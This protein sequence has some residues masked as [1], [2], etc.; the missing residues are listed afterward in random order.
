MNPPEPSTGAE[1]AR[2]VEHTSHARVRAAAALRRL[3]NELIVHQVDDGLLT[4]IAELAEDWADQVGAQPQRG[5]AFHLPD[6]QLFERSMIEGPGARSPTGFPDSLVSGLANPHSLAAQT[7]REGEEAVLAVVLGPTAEGAPSRAHGGVVAALIDEA[8]GSVLSIVGTPAFTGRLTI[9][10]RSPTPIGVRIE[11]RARLA[12][13]QGRKLTIAASA[14]CPEGLVAEA[15]GLFVAVDQGRF[16]APP[17][18]ASP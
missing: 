11:V 8:M 18:D 1:G 7:W 4:H 12:G 14:C 2:E 17:K 3:G 9:T 6:A 10:Y 5:H 16:L 13:R 15:E